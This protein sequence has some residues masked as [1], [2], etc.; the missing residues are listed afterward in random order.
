MEAYMA[1]L[2][3]VRALGCRTLLP[4]HGAPLP[5]RAVEEALAHRRARE[6]RIL[7]VLRLGVDVLSAAL[8]SPSADSLQALKQRADDLAK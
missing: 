6:A 5:G 2:E 4:A 1:S 7:E 8:G 3:R